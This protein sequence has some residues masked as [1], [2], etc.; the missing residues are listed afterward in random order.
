[1]TSILLETPRLL[2]RSFTPADA[3]AIH[4]ILDQAFGDGTLI[5]DPAALQE[6]RAWVQWSMLSHEWFPKLHQPPYGDRAIV[7]KATDTLIGSVGYVPCLDVFEQLPSLRATAR[8]SGY[9]TPE[10]GLFWVVDPGQQRQGYATEAGQAMIQHAFAQLRLKRII[11]T[12]EYTN[13]ASQ[14]V[15]RKLGMRL[16]RNP[17]PEPRWLQVVG[18]LDHPDAA[19]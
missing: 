8:P 16:E 7:L 10:V 12:T 13:L 9:A 6:R 2:I 17:L 5:G 1:V 14:A 15:M 3:P 4:R 19:E 11:A 18:S